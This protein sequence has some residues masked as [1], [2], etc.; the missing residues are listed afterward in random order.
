MDST[1]LL[2]EQLH[3]GIHIFEWP[4]LSKRLKNLTSTLILRVPRYQSHSS[5]ISQFPL[6]FI[7]N[8]IVTSLMLSALLRDLP[9]ALHAFEQAIARTLGLYTTHFPRPTRSPY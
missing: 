9:C 5:W 8:V 6:V 3:R 1:S 7:Y 4:H 2:Q